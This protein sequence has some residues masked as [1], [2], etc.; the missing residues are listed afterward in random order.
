[1]AQQLQRCCGNSAVS[2]VQGSF[3]QVSHWSGP[4]VLLTTLSLPKSL[5]IQTTSLHLN[6]WKNR[7]KKGGATLH[8]K[9]LFPSDICL[10]SFGITQGIRKISALCALSPLYRLFQRGTVLQWNKSWARISVVLTVFDW[11]CCLEISI[12]LSLSL[13]VYLVL[14][15]S[16]KRSTLL[17]SGC[18]VGLVLRLQ[19]FATDHFAVVLQKHPPFPTQ[20]FINKQFLRFLKVYY[21]T[22]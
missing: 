6:K 7:F 17:L 14:F 2:G 21:P 16:Q 9:T 11:C 1:M 22:T 5:Q 18:T 8:E 13:S 10:Y 4:S 15:W 3:G 12:S 20:L 19:R